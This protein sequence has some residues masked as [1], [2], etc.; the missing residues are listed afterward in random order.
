[1]DNNGLSLLT[2]AEHENTVFRNLYR[3]SKLDLSS[4][5]IVEVNSNFLYGMT[6]LHILNL[7]FNP[8]VC[9]ECKSKD[10]C[11]DLWSWCRLRID[12]CVAR[13]SLQKIEQETSK[14][15]AMEQD[16]ITEVCLGVGVGIVICGT[17]I[18]VTIIVRRRQRTG[19]FFPSVKD[20]ILCQRKKQVIPTQC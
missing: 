19:K 16:L 8:A 5:N 2:K 7:S 18:L 13:C 15:V 4:N 10:K 6:N 20:I 3:L 1:L 12:R 14:N 9:G 17:C 11:N